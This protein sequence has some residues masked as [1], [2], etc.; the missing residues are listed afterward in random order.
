[1]YHPNKY[2]DHNDAL[3]ILISKFNTIAKKHGNEVEMYYQQRENFRDDGGVIFVKNGIKFLFD[4][5]KR[6][7]YYAKCKN[8]QFDTLGQF[9]RKIQKKEIKLSI[10]C[11][12]DEQCLVIAWHEDYEKESIENIHSVTENGDT[13]NKGKRFTKDFIEVPIDRLDIL[14]CIF[15]EA[16]ESNNFNKKSFCMVSSPQG[17]Y[18]NTPIFDVDCEDL[19]EFATRFGSNYKEM[20]KKE[21]Y[22][23][24]C[25]E[26]QKID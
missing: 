6:H 21:I 4:F 2:K 20:A 5:E 14:Y 3:N 24:M 19:I 26:N 17:K 8:L 9:E 11:S 13:E 7:T 10:Q 23:R 18:V 25:K 1:M 16:F 22:R 12:T 15:V